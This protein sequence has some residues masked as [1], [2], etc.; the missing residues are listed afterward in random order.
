MTKARKLR[1]ETLENRELLSVTPLEYA[2]S[3]ELYSAFEQS[4]N[5]S[6]ANVV[7]LT[8]AMMSA[9]AQAALDAAQATPQNDLIA[10]RT[11]SETWSARFGQTTTINSSIASSASESTEIVVGD[12]SDGA[13]A[14]SMEQPDAIAEVFSFSFKDGYIIDG[15]E[16]FILQPYDYVYVRRS[17]GYQAQGKVT[18]SGEVMFPGEYVLTNKAERLSDLVKRSGGLNKWAYVRGARLI[19]YTLAEER[20]RTR[21]G[22]VVLTSGK[23][24]VNVE[25][26][27]LDQ[28]YSVGI[29]LEAALADPGCEADLVL[30]RKDVLL[31]PEYINTVK[32][33]GNVMYPNVV[34][35]NSSFTV[36]DYVN[37]AGGYGYRPK[38]S[39]AYVVYMNGTIA[40]ARQT[41]KGVVEPG[42]EIVIPQRRERETNI[43]NILS[44]ATTSS[45]IATMLATIYNIIAP[46]KA[47]K[48]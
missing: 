14:K 22:L 29:D 7:D 4:E 23:D 46:V 35:Y 34:G 25:N 13:T 38:R 30:R 43:Q 32:I 16:D 48:Q 20:N 36:K 28:T 37:M 8:A 6:E 11:T 26:L 12:V 21:A 27:D 24:S 19:R 33:S 41:S 3:R 45:S 2:E 44:I 18:I 47:S 31:I 10:G 15:G 17:P 40:R 5:I 9:Q 39:K 1:M 42:C